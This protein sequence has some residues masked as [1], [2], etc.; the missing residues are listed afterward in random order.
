MSG[1]DDSKHGETAGEIRLE[2]VECLDRIEDVEDL[3]TIRRLCDHC[4][5][6]PA[7]GSESA[8][9]RELGGESGPE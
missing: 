9:E 2:I 6:I 1:T 4:L 3:W 5:A 7:G 8:A